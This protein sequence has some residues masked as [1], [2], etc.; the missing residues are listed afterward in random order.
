ME[1]GKN[2]KKLSSIVEAL[3]EYREQNAHILERNAG[4][5]IHAMTVSHPNIRPILLQDV[6]VI[7]HLKA[8]DLCIELLGNVIGTQR[9]MSSQVSLLL[10]LERDAT[11]EIGRYQPVPSEDGEIYCIHCGNPSPASLT[12]D[13]SSDNSPTTTTKPNKLLA[14]PSPDKDDTTIRCI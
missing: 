11:F 4:F 6:N 7:N 3:R 14:P 10:Q 2:I 9:G 13:S 12:S 1:F 8:L 5:V